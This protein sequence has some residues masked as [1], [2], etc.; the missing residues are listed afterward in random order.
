M[1]GRTC[2]ITGATSGIGRVT[3]RVLSRGGANLLIVGRDP[4]RGEATLAELKA[5]GGAGPAEMLHGDLASQSSIRNLAHEVRQRTDRLHVLI[6]NAGVI[7]LTRRL[8]ADAIESTLAVNHL[9]PFLL[10]S[11]LEDLLVAAAPARVITVASGAHR[12]GRIDFDDLQ[13][14]RR[15]SGFGAYAQSK[16]ANVLF[17]Y[18]LARRLDGRGVTANCLH[19]GAVDTRLWRESHGLLRLALRAARPFFLTAE[20]GAAGLVHLASSAALEG[21]SGRYFARL[22]EVRSSLASYDSAAAKRLWEMSASLAPN[23][24]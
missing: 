12:V 15:F 24:A 5:A 6:N 8:T 23:A 14:E 7:C 2:L 22:R 13:G 11:L 10:T 4:R 1:R 19:P 9:A 18:E 17:T 3:A 16:L 20:Q 21:V